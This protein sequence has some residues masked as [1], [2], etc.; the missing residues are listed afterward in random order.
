[1]GAGTT[2]ICSLIFTLWRAE[3]TRRQL[4]ARTAV[5]IPVKTERVRAS[6][7]PW[8]G[9]TSE[10]EILKCD[11]GKKTLESGVREAGEPAGRTCVWRDERK[12][13]PVRH[14]F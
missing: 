7:Q 14:P 9:W 5:G 12:K 4:R 2:P 6:A 13:K 10:S 8:L 1:M 11:A 3:L